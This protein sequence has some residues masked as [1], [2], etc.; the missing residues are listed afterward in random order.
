MFIAL[1]LFASATPFTSVIVPRGACSVATFSISLTA[2]VLI[3]LAVITC[4]QITFATNIVMK[5]KVSAIKT[6]MRLRASAK[7]PN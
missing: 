4:T 5:I 7:L 2:Q 1:T 3:E 6:W